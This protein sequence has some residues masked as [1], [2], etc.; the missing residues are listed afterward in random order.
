MF[1][2]TTRKAAVV[3][4]SVVSVYLS[5]CLSVCQTITFENLDIGPTKFI[6]AHPVNRQNIRVKFVYEG[7]RVTVTRAKKTWNVPRY[8]YASERM[9]T[10]VAPASALRHW[11]AAS[12][13]DDGK[14]H[15][16]CQCVIMQGHWRTMK[17]EYSVAY[18]CNR[19]HA[20]AGGLP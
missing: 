4:T 14:F 9:T 2:P 6:F 13:H 18:V 5:V 19:I 8:P 20:F 15:A 1:R 17:Y 7:H 11:G 16:S 12:K 10:T 3:I